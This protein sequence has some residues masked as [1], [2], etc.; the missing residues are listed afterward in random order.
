VSAEGNGDLQTLISV[1]AERLRQC[2]T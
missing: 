1:L 2:H